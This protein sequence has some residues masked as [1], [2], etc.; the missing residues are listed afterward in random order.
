MSYYN[1]VYRKRI[2]RYGLDYQ[3]RIQ[4]QREDNFDKYLLKSIYRVDFEYDSEYNPASLERYKQ[5]ESGTFSYLLTRIDLEMNSGVILDI[6]NQDNSTTKWLVLWKEHIE[7]S[8]YNKYLVVRAEREILI[9][10]KKAFGGI[11]GPGDQKIKDT[12][13]MK[14]SLYFENDNLYMLIT[15]YDKEYNKNTTLIVA[16]GEKQQTFNIVGIDNISTPGISY[17]TLDPTYTRDKTPAPEQ[18]PRDKDED[19]FWLNGGV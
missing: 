12:V 6:D 17:L 9:N 7:S 15:P 13:I 16:A 10:D 4:G 18:T 2:N 11:F 8:G 19:F 5:D 3:S 1:D 14:K